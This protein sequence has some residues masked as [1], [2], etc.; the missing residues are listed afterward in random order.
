MLDWRQNLGPSPGSL[1]VT[2]DLAV[3]TFDLY[4]AIPRRVTSGQLSG[5]VY[6]TSVISESGAGELFPLTLAG[7][8]ELLE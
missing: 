3:L 2:Y 1:P 6:T 7:V 8:R 5:V 4:A